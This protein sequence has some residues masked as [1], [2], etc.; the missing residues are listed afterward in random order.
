VANHE[1]KALYVALSVWT[2]LF[3]LGLALKGAGVLHGQLKY[4]V[5]SYLLVTGMIFLHFRGPKV[6]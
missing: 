2:G 5:F 3:V 1:S 4:T 6:P